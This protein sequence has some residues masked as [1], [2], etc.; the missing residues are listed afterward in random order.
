MKVAGGTVTGTGSMNFTVYSAQQAPN[1]SLPRSG[2]IQI[3]EDG[4]NST[5]KTTVKVSQNP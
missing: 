2:N 3:Y 1:P 4:S 5:A